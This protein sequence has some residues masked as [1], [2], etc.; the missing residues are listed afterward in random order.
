M[1]WLLGP[2]TLALFLGNADI[3]QNFQRVLRVFQEMLGREAAACVSGRCRGDDRGI[4]YGVCQETTLGRVPS[5]FTMTGRGVW[6]LLLAGLI[7]S[8]ESD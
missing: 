1:N 2:R 7:A 6:G 4:E 5:I 3:P 8:K